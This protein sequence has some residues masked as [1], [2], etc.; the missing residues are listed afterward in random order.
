[1]AHVK[2]LKLAKPVYA[3]GPCSGCGASGF[4]PGQQ[5]GA[6]QNS[7]PGHVFGGG[8][9]GGA[10]AH[11]PGSA[12]AEINRKALREIYPSITLGCFMKKPM[13][14]DYLLERIRSEMD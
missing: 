4:A 5:E 10:S 9:P 14:M 2:F 6:A 3:P 11:A 12:S 1:L 8:G 13:T 7:A